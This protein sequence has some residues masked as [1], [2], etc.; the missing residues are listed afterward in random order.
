MKLLSKVMLAIAALVLVG[1]TSGTS[2]ADG[3]VLVSPAIQKL[4]P[5]LAALN[6]QHSGNNTFEAG[7]GSSTGSEDLAPGDINAGP[8]QHTRSLTD[9]RVPGAHDIRV[10]AHINSAKGLVKT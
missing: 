9:L 7:R 1:L 4:V 2:Y 10:R 3:I 5:P 8:H 6:L